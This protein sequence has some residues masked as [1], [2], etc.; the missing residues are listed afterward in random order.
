MKNKYEVRGEITIIYI[1]YKDEIIETVV[2]TE[3]LPMLLSMGV[4]WF[5]WK[6]K[7]MKGKCYV[8]A[9][10]PN[11]TAGK[12]IVI[13]LHKILYNSGTG[14]VVDHINRDPLDNRKTNL[15]S[16]THKQNSENRTDSD[17]SGVSWSRASRKWKAYLRISGKQKHLGYYLTQQEAREVCNR[18]KLEIAV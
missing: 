16:V 18:A 6:P 13:W 11:H 10:K 8:K 12:R 5:A 9:N 15:R 7:K 14:L 3:D 1:R 17:N 4:T 2:D